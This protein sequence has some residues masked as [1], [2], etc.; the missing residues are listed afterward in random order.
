M[1]SVTYV[2]L[3]GLTTLVETWPKVQRGLHV[4]KLKPKNKQLC[5]SVVTKALLGGLR[6]HDLT[7]PSCVI[8]PFRQGHHNSLSQ[9]K[10]GIIVKGVKEVIVNANELAVVELRVSDSYRGIGMTKLTD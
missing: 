3:A 10:Q 6:M 7:S 5:Q 8:P 1:D 2:S 9:E 4:Q